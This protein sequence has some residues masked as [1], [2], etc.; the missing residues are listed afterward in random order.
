MGVYL[1]GMYLTG[2]CLMGMHLLG[3]H[4][5]SVSL[6]GMYL[7]RA[8]HIHVLLMRVYLTVVHLIGV[9]LTGVHLTGVSPRFGELRILARNAAAGIPHLNLGRTS[10]L[11]APRLEPIVPLVKPASP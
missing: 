2:V 6:M 1:M 8:S 10:R 9:Y 7:R 4:L 5:T 3:V 11:R